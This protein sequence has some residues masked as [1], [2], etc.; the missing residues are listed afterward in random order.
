MQIAISLFG[1]TTTTRRAL[2][3]WYLPI[4]SELEKKNFGSRPAGKGG[5][6]TGRRGDGAKGREGENTRVRG[7]CGAWLG[8]RFRFLTSKKS[9]H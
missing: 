2:G 8:G 5:G 4:V 9:N 3:A 6:A 7:A 1:V